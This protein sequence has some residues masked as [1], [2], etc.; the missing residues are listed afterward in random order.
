MKINFE[1]F[2]EFYNIS[3]SENKYL[4]LR[5]L[6]KLKILK[7]ENVLKEL[8]A[9]GKFSENVKHVSDETLEF[10][11]TDLKTYKEYKGIFECYKQPL[12]EMVDNLFVK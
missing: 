5:L 3:Q 2:E 1:K 9:L 10:L 12:Y 8:Y 11:D 7:S 4:L 6:N